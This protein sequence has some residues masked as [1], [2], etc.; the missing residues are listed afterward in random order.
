M[1]ERAEERPTEGSSIRDLAE[2][3]PEREQDVLALSNDW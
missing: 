3:P 2:V 1:L